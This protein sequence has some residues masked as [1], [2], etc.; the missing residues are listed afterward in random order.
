MFYP[1]AKCRFH[2]REIG[3]GQ[4]AGCWW[5]GIGRCQRWRRGA[6]SEARGQAPRLE[7]GA[8]SLPDECS[9]L[10]QSDVPTREKMQSATAATLPVVQA[11]VNRRMQ[12]AVMAL[13][14]LGTN[15][16]WPLRSTAFSVRRP[17]CVFYPVAKRHFDQRKRRSRTR[18][19]L[20][21][22]H[23]RP[24]SRLR[25]SS[26]LLPGPLDHLCRNDQVPCG[27]EG[28]VPTASPVGVVGL[29]GTV[30]P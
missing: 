19:I 23:L 1:V 4:R 20:S 12:P 10:L 28:P 25:P 16:P 2:W 17:V 8:F 13:R 14:T 7:M 21:P 26:H 6:G 3:L 24:V 22:P 27:Y 15:R 30:L 9:T 11:G 5:A 29:P 18:R